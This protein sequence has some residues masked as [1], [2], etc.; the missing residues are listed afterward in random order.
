MGQ[1]LLRLCLRSPFRAAVVVV[2]RQFLF[3]GVD[4]NDRQVLLQELLDLRMDILKLRIAVRM[5]LAFRGLGVGMQIL[6]LRMEKFGHLAVADAIPLPLEFRGQFACAL[7]C[8]AQE[9]LR[10]AP[11]HGIHQLL[12]GLQQIGMMKG[13]RLPA[14]ARST[15]TSRRPGIPFALLQ[16]ANAGVD[17]GSRQ[18]G[19]PWRTGAGPRASPSL[20]WR[21][22]GAG[23]ELRHGHGND[24][25]DPPAARARCPHRGWRRDSFRTSDSAQQRRSGHRSGEG[26]SAGP[27]GHMP[28]RWNG[29]K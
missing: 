21:K 20:S 19:S 10:A 29:L 26:Q 13:E 15:A 12:Q 6:S 24:G 11:R 16:L 8:P 22:P 9:R 3:P 23:A 14:P 27:P 2:S 25:V 5:L 28:W 18:T 1:G 4:G 17:R 7:R